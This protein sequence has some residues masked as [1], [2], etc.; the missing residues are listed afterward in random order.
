[1]SILISNHPLDAELSDIYYFDLALRFN[2]LPNLILLHV[3]YFDIPPIF[4]ST[5]ESRLVLFIVMLLQHQYQQI[6]EVPD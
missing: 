2:P 4:F 1:M 3:I 5:S 6:E